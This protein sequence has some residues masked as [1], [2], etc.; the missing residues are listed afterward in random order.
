MDRAHDPWLRC[1][2]IR[3]LARVKEPTS[4]EFLM[5]LVE[6]EP[7]TPM[8]LPSREATQQEVMAVRFRQARDV[9]AW[10]AAGLGQLD[11]REA[12]P[13]LLRTA[14]DES[15]FF[16]RFMSMNSLVAWKAR[17]GLPVFL[18]RTGDPFPDVRALALTGLARTGDERVA[19]AVVARLSDPVVQVRVAAVAALADLAPAP[20]AR[21]ALENLRKHEPDPSVQ[22]AIEVALDRL[23]S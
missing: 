4:V 15:N 23:G 22:Q 9:R 14:E 18:R 8:A 13:L 19:G 11:A 21:P 2:A 12:L 20:V 16:L 10:A 3:Q 1:E 6:T 7:A 5:R 17:E